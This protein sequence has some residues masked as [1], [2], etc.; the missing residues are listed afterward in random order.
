MEERCGRRGLQ[1]RPYFALNHQIQPR[2]HTD[3]HGFETKDEKINRSKQIVGAA[4]LSDDPFP[5]RVDPCESAVDFA[6][7]AV[8]P[9]MLSPAAFSIKNQK[10]KIENEYNRPVLLELR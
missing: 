2:I 7:E 1:S 4:Q 3:S 8:N 6:V 10:S 5:I 9:K